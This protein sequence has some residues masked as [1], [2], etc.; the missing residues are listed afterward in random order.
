M[1]MKGGIAD[2]SEWRE[3][4]FAQN[5]TYIVNDQPCD[6]LKSDSA[7]RAMTSIPRNLSFKHNQA[8][9]H[10]YYFAS[11]LTES[12]FPF[13]LTAAAADVPGHSG[14]G[15]C[16]HSYWNCVSHVAAAGGNEQTLL[17]IHIS[18]SACSAW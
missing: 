8:G 14:A 5:C 1:R 11:L 3:A 16:D 18:L 9:E 13:N 10:V 2:I 15:R 6:L 7:P 4:E 12:A 17:G